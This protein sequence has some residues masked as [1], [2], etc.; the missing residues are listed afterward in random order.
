M[1][2]IL[3]AAAVASLSIELLASA[4]VPIVSGRVGTGDF[5][6]LIVVENRTSQAGECRFT[7]GKAVAR[8][9]FP[10]GSRQNCNPTCSLKA[11]MSTS[12]PVTKLQ[13]FGS[14]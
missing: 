2:A 5:G 9:Q 12:V 13:C 10:P 1:R 7:Y 6:T 3:S 8:Q 11:V 14:A 4:A